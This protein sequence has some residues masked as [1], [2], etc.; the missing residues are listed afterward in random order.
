MFVHGFL[1]GLLG[2]LNSL[3]G[4]RHPCSYLKLLWH[5]KL[6][7]FATNGRGWNRRHYLFCLYE[8]LRTCL[9]LSIGVVDDRTDYLLEI[10][11]RQTS[12][13]LLVVQ[14]CHD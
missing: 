2:Q 7:S 4:R 11:G 10:V 1:E 12:L 14:D 13:Q 3:L 9:T 6:I 8:S 5:L